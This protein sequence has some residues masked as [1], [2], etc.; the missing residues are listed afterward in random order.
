VSLQPH[1]DR[2]AI[3]AFE[4]Q[5]HASGVLNLKATYH[6][7]LDACCSRST[8]PLLELPAPDPARWEALFAAVRN[9]GFV[10]DWTAAMKAYKA[11]RG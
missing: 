11:A 1:V 9:S 7:P 3:L 4:E 10:H 8:N 6:S 2:H 5:M